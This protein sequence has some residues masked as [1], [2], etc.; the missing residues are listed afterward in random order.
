MWEETALFLLEIP[1]IDEIGGKITNIIEQY[2][3]G[4]IPKSAA[5]QYIILH[6]KNFI[7]KYL[8]MNKILSR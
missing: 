2:R 5:V 3:L 4:I 6:H 1:P 7:E 8:E